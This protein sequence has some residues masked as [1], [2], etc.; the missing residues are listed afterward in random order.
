[1]PL[2]L[3][4]RDK[5][6]F[7]DRL[8]RSLGEQMLGPTFRAPCDGTI[9]FDEGSIRDTRIQVDTP[10]PPGRLADIYAADRRAQMR[11]VMRLAVARFTQLAPWT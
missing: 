8:V 3:A 2:I 11:L 10:F 9:V 7:V 6:S 4:A 1:M 5:P